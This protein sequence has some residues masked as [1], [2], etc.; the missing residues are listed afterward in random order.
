MPA[1]LERERTRTVRLHE[2]QQIDTRRLDRERRVIRGVKIIGLESKNGRRYDG[3]ALRRAIPMYEGAPVYTNHDRGSRDRMIED[4]IGS[5]RNVRFDRDGLYGDLHYLGSH[6]MAARLEEAVERAPHL[7]GLSHNAEGRVERVNGENVVVE[8][9]RV[10]SVDMVAN[11]AT[12]RGLFEDSAVHDDN[13]PT[14]TEALPPETATS[15]EVMARVGRVRE[16][17]EEGIL[18]V[19]RDA[20]LD[21]R[22]KMAR[23]NDLLDELESSIATLQSASIEAES[24]EPVRESFPPTHEAFVRALRRTGGP[25]DRLAGSRYPNGHP[26]PAPG[27]KRLLET[28]AELPAYPKDH[29]C[30][31]RALR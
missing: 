29:E 25:G 26:L 23:V 18:D 17:Y 13:D 28:E 24:N 27:R 3:S 21:R 6:P 10:H 14:A 16:A 9:E 1:T 2:H 22:T 19:L 4:K 12:V 30:F 8:I 20:T 5:L 31:L 11:G 15:D 7:F